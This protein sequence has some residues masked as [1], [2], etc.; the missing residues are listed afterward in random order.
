M[1]PTDP[2]EA[3]FLRAYNIRNYDVPLTSVDLAIFTIRQNTLQVLLV[4]RGDFPFKGC[5]ALPGGFIDVHRDADLNATALRKLREKTGVEAPYLEQVQGF[6]G[7]D[8]DP[9]GWSTTFAYFALIAA[10]SVTPVE[11]AG[12][13]E[14]RWVEVDVEGVEAPLAFDHGIILSTAIHRLRN[15]VEYTSL[16]VHL[17]PEAFTLSELQQ[18]HETILGKRLDKSAFRKRIRDGDYL[19]AIPDGL[20]LGSN[21]PAQ[22]YRLRPDSETIYFSRTMSGRTPFAV[23]DNL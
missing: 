19:E 1:H 3:A 20:R 8:R 7:K 2:E 10:D 9:R 4:R 17:L 16:P 22:L 12:V 23:E 18:V 21:R 15:K 14:V 5:W 13:D 11:G 6:G